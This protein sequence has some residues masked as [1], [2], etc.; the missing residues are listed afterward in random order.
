[1]REDFV[2]FVEA[3]S[4]KGVALTETFMTP[5]LSLE[6]TSIECEHKDKTVL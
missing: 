3:E 5:I 2:W 1:M 4:T 6:L